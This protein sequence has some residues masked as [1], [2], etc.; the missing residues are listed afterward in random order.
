MKPTQIAKQILVLI[1]G[2]ILGVALLAVVYC[3]PQSAIWENTAI[4]ADI[5]HDE[6]PRPYVLTGVN[7]SKLDNHTDP[8]MLDILYY[9]TGSFTDD[10]LLAS[11]VE[12]KDYKP[13][14]AL[15]AY[16]WD[17]NHDYFTSYYSRYW[18]GYQVVLKPM[19]MLFTLSSIRLI[20]FIAQTG[21][22]FAVMGILIVK[23]RGELAIPFF[24][25]WVCL[26]PFTVY[27][28]L[29]Y[30]ST[31][32]V[33]MGLSLLVVILYDK[34]DLAKLCILFEIGGIAEVS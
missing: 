7:A 32:Y 21:L 10:V 30:S 9:K 33:T 14:E 6:D 4:S 2:I 8:L 13:D 1:I 25:A 18:H 34:L 31:F 24:A 17:E 22:A 5:L 29:Q 12:V 26:M 3:I 15:F 28:S 19:L 20:N 23:K 11:Y 16:L 27:L